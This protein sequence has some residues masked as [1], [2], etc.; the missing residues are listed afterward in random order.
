MIYKEKRSKIKVG[1]SLKCM[2]EFKVKIGFGV[3]EFIIISQQE[4][5]MAIRAQITGK[6]AIFNE[7]TVAG[8]NIIFITPYFNRVMGWNRLYQPDFEDYNLLGKKRVDAA[9]NLFGETKQKVLGGV[10][11]KKLN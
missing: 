10:D 8:N 7:G 5:E 1:E 9:R 11:I 4:L 6:I 3:D 2:Q